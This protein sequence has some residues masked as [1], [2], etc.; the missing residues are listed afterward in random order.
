M[1]IIEKLLA[2]HEAWRKRV[3]RKPTPRV[4]K[5]D[6]PKCGAYARSTD[7]PCKAKALANG[8][9]K[10]HGG[11]STGPKTLEGKARALANFVQNRHSGR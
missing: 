11:R 8:R 4:T 6:R 1:D 2:E 7:K 3:S 5:K 10:N 9:C